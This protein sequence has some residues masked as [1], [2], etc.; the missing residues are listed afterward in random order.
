MLTNYKKMLFIILFSFSCCKNNTHNINE[1][2]A[3]HI[4]I[5]KEINE[6]NNL[7]QFIDSAIYIPLE[8]NKKSI[9]H[10]ITRFEIIEDKIIIFDKPQKSIL[11]FDKKGKFLYKIG[12]I[13]LDI[14]DYN[15][16]LPGIW[17]TS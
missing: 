7:N 2:N 3:V 6:T 16:I 10:T 4:K 13:G 14:M 17:T 5:D 15:I 9:I 11:F 12:K 8:T 1:E